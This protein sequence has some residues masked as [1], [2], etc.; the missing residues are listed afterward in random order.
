M[1]QIVVDI[2][3]KDLFIALLKDNKCI[4]YVIKRGLIKKTDELPKSFSYIIKKN[5]IDIK[6][7]NDYYTT[8]G[9]GSFTGSRSG[10]IFLKTICMINNKIFILVIH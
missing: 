4:D 8:N 5:N 1:Y 9:P 7:I 10:Y 3:T 6:N 2:S